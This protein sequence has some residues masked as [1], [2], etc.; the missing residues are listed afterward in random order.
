M[1]CPPQPSNLLSVSWLGPNDASVKEASEPC[2]RRRSVTSKLT[3]FLPAHLCN[4]AILQLGSISFHRLDND[5]LLPSTGADG[6]RQIQTPGHKVCIPRT[7]L[8]GSR[9]RRRKGP[10]R[11]FEAKRCRIRY[12]R[13][14]SRQLLL[15][16]INGDHLKTCY[17]NGT[18]IYIRRRGTLHELSAADDWDL[19]K[20]T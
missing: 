8:L 4:V 12:W 9:P 16:C 17:H 5:R 3:I 19:H 6:Q 18:N 2:P 15:P 10:C 11:S 1:P 20:G 13:P 7:L 14:V